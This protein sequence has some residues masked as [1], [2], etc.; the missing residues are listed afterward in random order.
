[1]KK[2]YC[3]YM[4]IEKVELWRMQNP[5]K[6][7]NAFFEKCLDDAVL[8]QE[9][10]LTRQMEEKVKQMERQITFYKQRI[11]EQNAEVNQHKEQMWASCQKAL[12]GITREEFEEMYKKTTGETKC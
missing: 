12:K 5:G 3:M 10:M 7:I 2:N 8:T 6:K 11:E 1:M 9:Q 4:S